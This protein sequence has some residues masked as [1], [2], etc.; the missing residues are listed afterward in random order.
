M[1]ARRARQAIRTRWYLTWSRLF[2]RPESMAEVLFYFKFVFHTH[3]L[4]TVIHTT[5]K[6]IVTL[7]GLQPK[8]SLRFSSHTGTF[9]IVG[10]LS[11]CS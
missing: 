7:G 8:S 3:V 10:F 11:L 6:E 1:R 4:Q 2:G 9:G 5:M